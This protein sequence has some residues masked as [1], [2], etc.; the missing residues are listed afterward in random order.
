MDRNTTAKETTEMTTKTATIV[1]LPAKQGWMVFDPTM[2]DTVVGTRSTTKRE[3]I[4]AAR[5]LG[6]TISK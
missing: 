2:N 5:E 6:Y 3:A 4:E 1:K